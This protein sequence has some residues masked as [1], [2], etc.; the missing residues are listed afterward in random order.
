MDA[1]DYLHLQL[2]LEG[3]DVVGTDSLRPV[4]IVPDEEMP[5]MLIAQLADKQVVAYYDEALSIGLHTELTQRIQN[6]ALPN[7]DALLGFL[8]TQNI[9]STVGHYKTY[10][11]LEKQADFDDV[12][13]YTKYDPKV[14]A[15]GFDGFSEEVYAIEQDNNIVSACVS[16]RENNFCGEA[17]V[18]TDEK[19]R[20]QGFA[21]KVVSVWALSLISAGKV[22]FY[23]HKIQNNASANLAT[24]LGLQSVFEEIVIPYANV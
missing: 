19:Y 17:W 21:R 5:L 11:F 4:E 2:Q 13:C 20:H 16:T 14:K 15:F 18:Y 7:L 9:S 6:A 10:I 23:S 22:A 1:I 12:N 3:K 24:R 8:G